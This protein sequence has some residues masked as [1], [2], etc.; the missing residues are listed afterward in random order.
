MR[1]SGVI[2]GGPAAQAGLKEGDVIIEFAGRKITNIYDY[3]FALDS[4]KI[5]QTV[6][7]VCMRDG[8]RTE[9]SITPTSRP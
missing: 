6:A 8:Q 1:L 3:T 5:D 9:F 2:G 4:V 7:V